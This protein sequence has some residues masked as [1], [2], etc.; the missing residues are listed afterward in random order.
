MERW[1]E[2]KEEGVI[3]GRVRVY[4]EKDSNGDQK[5]KVLL[6]DP[7]PVPAP[8]PVPSTSASEDVKGKAPAAA[9]RP[10]PLEYKLTLQNTATKNM[11]IFGEK[12]EE[13]EESGAEGHRKRRRIASI[14]GTVHHEA[15]LTPD[16]S[17]VG[18]NSYREIMRERQRKASEPKRT[19]QRLDVDQGTANRLAAGQGLPGLNGIKGRASFVKV[20]PTGGSSNLRAAR[21]PRNELL[22]LLFALFESKPYWQIK[23]LTEHVQQP[24]TYLK[25]VL[26]D[27]GILVG[28]GPYNGMW[29]LKDEYKSRG[30][31]GAAVPAPPVAGPAPTTG[32]G[33]VKPKP[34]ELDDAD[35]DDD[36]DSDD[37]EV[38]A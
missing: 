7:P 9:R 26:A 10:I 6:N 27:I 23:A 1:S 5:I 36:S 4:E 32:D 3:L 31:N 29:T 2:T 34:E 14:K 21:I 11:Y 33:D 16:L 25:E 17:G 22:D 30:D 19:I 24:Q 8:A 20:K 37:M 13:V 15:S 12:E 35:E 38:I 28:R 18:S